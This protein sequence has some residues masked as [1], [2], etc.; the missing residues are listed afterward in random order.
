VDNVSIQASA[1][2]MEGFMDIRFANDV[3]GDDNDD[4]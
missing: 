1:K 2:A 3:G 4:E